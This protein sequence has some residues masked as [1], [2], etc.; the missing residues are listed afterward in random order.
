MQISSLERT[1]LRI[2]FVGSLKVWKSQDDKD[3][4]LIKKKITYFFCVH[5]W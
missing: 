5:N 4:P 2:V 1:F 3:M